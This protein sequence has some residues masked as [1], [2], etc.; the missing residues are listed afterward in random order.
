MNAYIAIHC[1]VEPVQPFSEILIAQ[2]AEIGFE[3]F[4][5]KEDGFDGFIRKENFNESLLETIEFLQPNEFCTAHWQLEEV[6]SQNWNEEWEKNY[7]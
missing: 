6:E 2:L 4:E 1:K 7:P 5:E 3:M